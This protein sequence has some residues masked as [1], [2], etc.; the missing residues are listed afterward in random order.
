[1]KTNIEILIIMAKAIVMTK[2]ANEII[3]TDKLKP[4]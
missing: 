4:G 1:M 2:M 3:T